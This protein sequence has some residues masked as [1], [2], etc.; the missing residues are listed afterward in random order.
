[1][2]IVR[3]FFGLT[4]IFSIILTLVVGQNIINNSQ[5]IKEV[6]AFQG[7]L[8]VWHIDSFEGG[9]SSRAKFLSSTARQ[10]EKK[11]KN[12]LIMV[13]THTIESV[14][15]NNRKGIFPD[16]ISFGCG[17]NIEN[18]KELNVKNYIKSG[19]I[20]NKK[21]VVPWCRG[22]YALISNKNEENNDN[23]IENLIVSQSQYT[24]PIASILLEG[25]SVKNFE[26]LSPLDAYIKFV[27]GKK[28][29]LLGTQRDI[30]RLSN[31]GKEVDVKPLVAYNDLYQYIGITSNDKTKIIYAEN[32]INYLLS[33]EVQNKL[34]K[35]NMFSCF[36]G[37]NFENEHLN[38]MQN[39]WQFKTVSPFLHSDKFIEMQNISI[40]AIRD[41]EQLNKIKKLLI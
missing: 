25:Y 19:I 5:A 38:K 21:F 35:I 36:Y 4:L 20:G 29:Y 14:Q 22:G 37:V 33:E 15:E 1:M 2:K 39:L 12:V 16:I 10:F 6:E 8:S 31:R 34:C 40:N 11:Y 41:I 24:Q 27:E 28:T 23:I 13:S 30:V 3:L 18:L 26:K 17:L 32:F 7:V 9:S